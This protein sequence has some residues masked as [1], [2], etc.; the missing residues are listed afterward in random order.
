MSDGAIVAR[1]AEYYAGRLAEH[2]ATHR[3]V[4]WNSSASQELRFEQLVHGIARDA[5]A[6]FLDWGCGYG[7]MARWLTSSMPV[8]HYVGFDIAPAM[9][10]AARTQ[11]GDL[12]SAHFTT[13]RQ[14][15][16]IADH[17]LASGIFNVKL[18]TPVEDWEAYVLHTVDELAAHARRGFA[19]NVLTSYSDRDR[20]RDDL[21]YADPLALFDHCKRHHS[22]H[23][24]LLHDYGLYEFTISVRLEEAL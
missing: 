2:G 16:S 9:V 1:V 19:F 17:V 7:A 12:C 20:K 3:G 18:D 6:A 10:E 23:V 4:D 22:R 24:A 13:E 14:S 15:L 8:R 5:P 11:Q 21:Y